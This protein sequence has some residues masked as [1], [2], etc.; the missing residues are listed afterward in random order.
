MKH[1]KVC[2]NYGRKCAAYETVVILAT[3]ADAKH[4]IKVM[5]SMCGFDAVIKKITVQEV[6]RANSNS[7]SCLAILIVVLFELVES[8]RNVKRRLRVSKL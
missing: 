5:A 6:N 8:R 2:I 7:F 3:E 4:R 1:F